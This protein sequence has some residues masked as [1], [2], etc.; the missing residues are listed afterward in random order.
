MKKKVA[1]LVL[2]ALFGGMFMTALPVTSTYAR[3][4]DEDQQ[5]QREAEQQEQQQQQQSSD[6]EDPCNLAMGS[7]PPGMCDEEHTE[8]TLIETISNVLDTVYLWVGIIAVI[9]III[10]GIN[11]TM[12]QGDPGKVKKAKDTVLY[13]IIGLI[14]ALLAFAITAFVMNAMEGNV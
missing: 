8:E 13:G 3:L 2:T 10:G 9:F 7:K 1:A 4:P 12:S 14:I 6:P 5:A 11:Y